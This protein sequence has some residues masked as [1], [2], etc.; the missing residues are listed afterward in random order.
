VDALRADS[1]DTTLVVSRLH[2]C[3]SQ[4]YCAAATSKVLAFGSG[5]GTATVLAMLSPSLSV[6]ATLDSKVALAVNGQ[7]DFILN[8]SK[9]RSH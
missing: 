6:I 4:F 5:P 1:T 3:W 9:D 2:H 7:N 8:Q